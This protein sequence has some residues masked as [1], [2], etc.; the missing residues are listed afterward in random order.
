[1]MSKKK[2]PATTSATHGDGE[3]PPAANF[4]L[5]RRLPCRDIARRS[6]QHH[7]LRNGNERVADREHPK[8]LAVDPLGTAA[9]AKAAGKPGDA[10]QRPEQRFS[11]IARERPLEPHQHSA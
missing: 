9:D 1:M 6:Q 8:D 10:Q 4:R 3:I 11:E 2:S 7:K 5:G